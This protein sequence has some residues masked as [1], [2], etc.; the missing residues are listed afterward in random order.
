MH[1]IPFRAA[2][3]LRK[4]NRHPRFLSVLG[5]LPNQ[6]RTLLKESGHEN[7]E[8][9]L[10]DISRTLF[11]AGFRVWSKRHHL[12]SYYWNHIAPDNRKVQTHLAKRKKHKVDN[13]AS[14]SKC[15]NLFH[16]LARHSNLSSERNTKCPCRT[17][18]Y[19]AKVYKTHP[20]TAFVYKFPRTEIPS[21]TNIKDFMTRRYSGTTWQRKKT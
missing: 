18:T 19:R 21:S 2:E 9:A 14:L 6:L 12:N 8:V 20:I 5:I 3:L 1:S 7:R 13:S 17:V 11:F 10:L 16:F 15:K 4:L